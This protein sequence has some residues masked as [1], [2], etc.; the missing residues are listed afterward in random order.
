MEIIPLI[1]A[2]ALSFILQFASHNDN[3][4]NDNVSGHWGFM[5]L[6]ILFVPIAI[7]FL[8]SILNNQLQKPFQTKLID[9]VISSS[10]SSMKGNTTN[11]MANVKRNGQVMSID[12]ND[13][14]VGD[15]CEVQ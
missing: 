14:L 12:R 2:I 4:E 9:S 15:I 7:V 11:G 1:S 13:L 3:E 5:I 8:I 6:D 10:S